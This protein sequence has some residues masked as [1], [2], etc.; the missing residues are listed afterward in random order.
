[1]HTRKT[2]IVATIG[3][4]SENERELTGMIHAGMNVARL[5]FSHGTHE[6]YRG[7]ISRVREISE[8][9]HTP[10]AILQDL[11]GPK[12]RIG[13]FET[14]TIHLRDGADFVLTT[15]EC[16]GDETR[17]YVN[18]SGLPKEVSEGTKIM[19]DDG[20]IQLR[21]ESVRG[22]AIHCTVV[23]GGI[24]RGMRGVNVP[25]THLEIG[26][27][28]KKDKED[29][30]FGAKH[31]V[32][33]VALS[34]VQSADDI[35]ALRKLLAHH[36]SHA[37]IIAKIET[38]EAVANIDSII[39]ATDGIMIARGD[40]AVE[41]P[42]ENVPLIQ[43]SIIKKS[44]EAG[45]PVI[46]ATQMLDSMIH[47]PVPTRA[48]VSDVSNAILDGTDAIMLSGET[49]N[50]D[51]PVRTVE[52]MSRIA[53]KTE[54]SELFQEEVRRFKRTTLG[55][56]D[57][58]G[59]AVKVTAGNIEAKAIVALT[60]TGFT[61]RMISRYKPSQPIFAL[62]PHVATCNR[63]LLSFGVV[64]EIGPDFSD[65][66]EAVD[67]AKKFLVHRKKLKEG[68]TFILCAGI[69]FGRSGSTNLMIAHT[70]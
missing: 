19:L 15:E 5:N 35:H 60:E 70:I 54:E 1:M 45:K 12:I 10:V 30:E 25:G 24:I 20:K 59:L 16:V 7:I 2:K 6:E 42:A 18:Y 57:S 17:A 9:I 44:I 27:L 53:L 40:L 34:F 52:T 48:E 23:Y 68:D 56:A 66:N 41:I 8:T 21:V 62:T 69:P 47:S 13:N 43:K 14:E 11:A 33:F 31:K 61:P 38:E 64:P 46:T 49:A 37:F 36:K 55:I 28:T 29:L 4:S 22:E 50:G 65:L 32:D 58:V 51:H 63:T 67:Y 39:E 3:P 26:C